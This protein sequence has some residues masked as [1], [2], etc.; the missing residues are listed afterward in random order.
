MQNYYFFF[1]RIN[2]KI[3]CDNKPRNNHLWMIFVKH[4][5]IFTYLYTCIVDYSVVKQNINIRHINVHTNVFRTRSIF[6]FQE[7]FCLN[8][9]MIHLYSV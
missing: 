5:S 6:F 1:E 2:V 9:Q 4:D 7:I 8:I 3:I